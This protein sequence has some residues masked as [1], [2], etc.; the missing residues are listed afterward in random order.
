MTIVS[1]PQ[2]DASHSCR[3]YRAAAMGLAILTVAVV[4]HAIS[5]FDTLPSRLTMPNVIGSTLVHAVW[6]GLFSWLSIRVKQGKRVEVALAVIMIN[7]IMALV[8]T[9]LLLSGRWNYVGGWISIISGLFFWAA[10]LGALVL[11][12]K[13]LVKPKY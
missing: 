10:W 8:P 11:S 4:L 3:P 7:G 12:I 2:K 13:A 6:A 1:Y 5:I 9:A